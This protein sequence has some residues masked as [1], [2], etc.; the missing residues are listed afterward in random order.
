MEAVIG[1]D[2]STSAVKALAFDR[3]GSVLATGRARLPFA[4]DAEGRF[5]QDPEDWWRACRAA[6]AELAAGLDGIEIAGLAI[7]NQRETI[8]P[9]D[10]GFRPVRPAILWLDGR[11][12]GDAAAMAEALGADHL[13]RVTGKIPDPNPALYKLAW[14]RRCEPERLGASAWFAEV[15]GYLVQRLTGRF[16]TSTASADPLGVYDLAAKRYADDLLDAIGLSAARFAPALPPGTK[17]GGLTAEAARATGL[18]EG[19]KVIAGAGD[20]QAAGLG[21]NVMEPGRAYLNLGT[22]VVAGMRSAS[23]RVGRGFRTM[24]AAD[25]EGYI[26][27]TSLRSGTLL[28]DWLTRDIFG[29]DA[30]LLAELEPAA[31]AL[32]PGSDGVMIL[33]YFLGVM[34]PHWDGAA[35]GAIVGLAPHHGRA[36]LLRALYEGIAL[37]QAGVMARIE[38]EAGLAAREIVAIGGGAQSDLWCAILA[39]AHG[40]PVLRSATVEATSLGAAMAAAVGAGWYSGFAEAA[41]AMAGAVTARFT[42]D[43]GRAALYAR[44]RRAH[45]GLYPALRPFGAA[46]LT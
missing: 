6:L 16:A 35:R 8:A 1:L 18:Q 28:C 37:E 42:P 25:G 26:L 4:P 10:A 3:Q 17:L 14:M 41:S 29:G 9:L 44:L 36:H 38:A 24:I 15:H 19:L 34:T 22:A 43:A 27:E 46:P 5:E 21:V 7:A 33:P 13:H 39:D 20:G 23:Y 40:V 32:P 30:A 45:A 11:A 2:C 12:A 31:A